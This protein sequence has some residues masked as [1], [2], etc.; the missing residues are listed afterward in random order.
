MQKNNTKETTKKSQIFKVAFITLI[1]N[2]VIFIFKLLAG[3]IDSSVALISDAVHTASDIIST[4]IVIFGAGLA[5]KKSDNEHRYGHERFESVASILLAVLL[6]ATGL[7]IGIEGIK[8]IISGAFK[9]IIMPSYLALSAAIMS[10]LVK[11][12]M[13]WYAYINAKRLKS[14][15]LKA[16]AWHHRSDAISS[17]GAMIGVIGAMLG[18]PILDVIASLV[19]CLLILKVAIE[20]F[21]D[22]IGGMT[23]KSCDPTT[24]QAMEK[25]VKEVDGVL[26]V[27]DIKTRL[28]GDRAYIDIEISADPMLTLEEA[29]TIAEK[30][31]N[32]IEQEFDIIKHCMVHVNPYYGSKDDAPSD[33]KN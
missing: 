17:V 18:Y 32:K 5:A 29:H 23:D 19:I 21:L 12:G 24:I 15:A 30:V 31:H 2:A 27:D 1:I 26:K 25:A 11:E 10:I 14:P 22:A 9:D 28:F 33:D 4:I 16:D 8:S 7:I 20:I 3:I 13:F 6:A